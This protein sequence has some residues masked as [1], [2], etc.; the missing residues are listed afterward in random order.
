MKKKALSELIKVSCSQRVTVSAIQRKMPVSVT[1]A[2]PRKQVGLPTVDR[3]E[4]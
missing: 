1:C 4:E 3:P 2:A